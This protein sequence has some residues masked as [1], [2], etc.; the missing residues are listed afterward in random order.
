MAVIVTKNLSSLRIYVDKGLDLDGNQIIGSKT[1]G[2][3]NPEAADQDLM[4]VANALVGL[5]KHTLFKVVRVDNSNLA[6]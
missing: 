2:N 1:Y 5:Q 3:I 4:D 6:E